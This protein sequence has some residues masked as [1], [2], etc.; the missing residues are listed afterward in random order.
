[1][2][3]IYSSVVP[4]RIRN[5]IFHRVLHRGCSEPEPVFIDFI[6]KIVTESSASVRIAEIGVEKGASTKKAVKLLRGGDVL[7]LYDR[8]TSTLFQKKGFKYS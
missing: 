1:M 6:K 5:L 2:K 4:L 7:D 8:S 3:K